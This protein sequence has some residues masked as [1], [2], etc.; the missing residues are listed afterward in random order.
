MNSEDKAVLGVY[1]GAGLVVVGLGVAGYIKVVLEERRKRKQ[2]HRDMEKSLRAI[3][4]ASKT[5][6]ERIQNGEY[7]GPDMLADVLL[8]FEFQQIV[9][10]DK[11]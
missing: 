6:T 11:E 4:K 8:D 2:I 5:V 7:G 3:K 1:A 9:E 10:F